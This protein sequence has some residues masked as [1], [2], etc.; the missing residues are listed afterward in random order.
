M[1]QRTGE[2]RNGITLTT[3]NPLAVEIQR[4]IVQAP[5]SAVTVQHEAPHPRNTYQVNK[6]GKAITLIDKD[7]SKVEI[8]CNLFQVVHMLIQLLLAF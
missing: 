1:H 6:R 8:F 3:A 7:D 4:T 5:G 2:Q